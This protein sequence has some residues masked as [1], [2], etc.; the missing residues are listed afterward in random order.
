MRVRLGI[1]D[2]ST[3]MQQTHFIWFGHLERMDNEN[4]VGKYI[5]LEIDGTAGT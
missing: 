3:V 1:K 2:I 4:W 5:S